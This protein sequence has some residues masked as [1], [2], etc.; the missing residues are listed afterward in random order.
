M[1][2][3]ACACP[4]SEPRHLVTCG[5][6]YG[7]QLNYRPEQHIFTDRDLYELM[8]KHLTIIFWAKWD[9]LTPEMQHSVSALANDIYERLTHDR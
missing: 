8:A 4:R 2:A 6:G 7:G 9:R 1:T 5:A 3:S